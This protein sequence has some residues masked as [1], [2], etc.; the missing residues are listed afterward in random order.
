MSV[1]RTAPPDPP[2]ASPPAPGVSFAFSASM[3]AQAEHRLR[4]QTLPPLQNLAL[5]TASTEVALRPDQQFTLTIGVAVSQRM[6][7]AGGTA[8][9]VAREILAYMPRALAPVQD[10]VVVWARI[11]GMPTDVE[12]V[13]VAGM[14]R[15]LVVDTW[16]GREAGGTAAAEASREAR[17]LTPVTPDGAPHMK[18]SPCDTSAS[19]TTLIWKAHTPE[20]QRKLREITGAR[21]DQ[22]GDIVQRANEARIGDTWDGAAKALAEKVLGPEGEQYL[23]TP[24]TRPK[25][26]A[27]E[28]PGPAVTE[29]WSREKQTNNPLPYE[30]TYRLTYQ[31]DEEND[32]DGDDGGRRV[33]RRTGGIGG[34][35]RAAGA[36]GSGT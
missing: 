24:L 16:F 23:I 20:Q 27:G 31:Y 32:A 19:A 18:I 2:E 30:I 14:I 28:R 10:D 26:E 34:G 5:K 4:T 15:Q 22:R 17:R 1:R 8:Q 9:I 35:G 7:G 13:I 21:V 3:L 12:R 25:Q 29:L 11:T 36:G 33:A 6:L